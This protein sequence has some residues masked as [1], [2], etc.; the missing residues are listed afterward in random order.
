MAS[1]ASSQPL[2]I[3]SRRAQILL[4]R[5]RENQHG[6]KP[7]T[8][9]A[10]P[11][12]E[13]TPWPNSIKYSFF[14]ACVVLVPMSIGQAIAMSPRLRDWILGNDVGDDDSAPFTSSRG[15]ISLVRNYWGNE[16]YVPPTDRP[17]LNYATPGYRNEWQED[18]VSS[19]LHLFG[20]FTPTKI[21]SSSDTV[22]KGNNSVSMSL[23]N[24]PSTNIRRDQSI[25]SQYL[26]SKTN[27]EGV[28]ARLTLIP[29][30]SNDIMEEGG[31]NNENA[32]YETECTFPANT[33]MNTLRALCQ[34]SD[35]QS[36]KRDLAESDPTFLSQSSNE[37]IRTKS[38]NEDCRWVV[39]FVDS[40]EDTNDATV[41]NAFDGDERGAPFT[42]QREQGSSNLLRHNTAIHSSWTY[43][44]ESSNHSPAASP[45]GPG[46]NAQGD[47]SDGTTTDTSAESL[48]ALR[49]QHQVATLE[50]ELKDPSSLRD[51]D[52]MYE[53]LKLAR[54][55]LRD[56]KPWWRR[57]GV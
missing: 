33:S 46:R 49:L 48:D 3:V 36:L 13:E 31:P 22:P 52:G 42:S 47:S 9:K 21:D 19:L 32:G 40:E 24:E 28:K 38:W 39:S 53:E 37:R 57:F 54:R 26:S 14:A 35:A 7:P 4:Q 6:Y 45:L 16:D 5:H 27:P 23:E 11:K 17:R 50:Q 44:P 56:L 51:R 29:R 8:V 18:H 34:G 43:F 20:M 10:A 15:I 25:L 30:G 12:Q 41:G 2:R 1:T 55:E